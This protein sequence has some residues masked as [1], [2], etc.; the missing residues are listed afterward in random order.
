MRL[1]GKLVTAH[2]ILVTGALGRPN[3]P[4]F[5][6]ANLFRGDVIHSSAY[7]GGAA[8][9]GRRVVVVGADQSAADLCQDL[10]V[11][12]ATEVTMVQRS[13]SCVTLREYVNVKA[14]FSE[15]VPMDVADLWDTSRPLGLARKVAVA[16]QAAVW[17]AHAEVHAKLCK[18]G[19]R[20]DLGP[21]GQ[22]VFPLLYE[23]FGGKCGLLFGVSPFN[24]CD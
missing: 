22:G 6:D 15:G 19:A 2:I 23:R 5:R 1:V 10:A 17:A 13:P 21:E 24:A 11:K 8:L 4:L 14:A 9:A 12:G 3:I 18:G 7:P 20:V 16:N